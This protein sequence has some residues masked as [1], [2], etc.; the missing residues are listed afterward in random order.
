[1]QKWNLITSLGFLSAIVLIVTIIVVFLFADPLSFF[2]KG[3][4]GK[5]SS[6]CLQN[7]A[8]KFAPEQIGEFTKT[9]SVPVSQS[10]NINTQ[11][12]I[13]AN[14]D[15]QK[16]L[17]ALFSDG[18]MLQKISEP[19]LSSDKE[20]T[21]YVEKMTK[22][23]EKQDNSAREK[24]QMERA[25][26][27]GF[28]AS[29][30]VYKDPELARSQERLPLIISVAINKNTLINLSTDKTLESPIGFAQDYF[31]ITCS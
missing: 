22:Y 12:A 31:K 19:I 3:T 15:N 25:T 17:V 4:S 5:I 24:F 27:S 21:E 23:L 30:T 9:Q 6:S 10:G 7:F 2:K 26:I 28:S 11:Q 16:L 20:W 18:D 1:M 29:I 13:Y 8:S 14:S